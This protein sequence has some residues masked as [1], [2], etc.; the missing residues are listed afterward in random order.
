[1]EKRIFKKKGIELIDNHGNIF[2][3]VRSLYKTLGIPK[4]QIFQSLKTQGFFKYNNTT[5]FLKN[6]IPVVVDNNSTTVKNDTINT[7]TK[8]EILEFQEFRKSKEV[9]K[10]PF[11]TYK[12]EPS[13][14]E[15]GMRY[16]VA[17]FS[18]AHIEETVIPSSI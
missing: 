13:T 18:D 15:C 10:L 3:S 7:V 14:K 1:M 2:P 5:Y 17:L 16:A 4:K 8:E 9:K 6:P 12:F 11:V